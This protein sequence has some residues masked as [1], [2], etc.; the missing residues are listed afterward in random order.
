MI[1][2]TWRQ[3]RVPA[4]AAV[5]GLVAIAILL[6]VTGHTTGTTE[7]GRSICPAGDGR[8][9][10]LS[11]V[12]LLQF[13]STFLVALPALTGAFWGAPLIAREL[14]TGTYRMAWTQSVTRTRWLLVKV[15]LVGLA[16]AAASGLLS[17]M[18]TLWSSHA[19][20][21]GR[22]S[23]PMF[24]ER[25][26]APIGDA[27]FAF[28]L[29]LTAGLVIRRTLPA[30][31]TTLVGFLAV[32]LVVTR[33]VRPHFA[34]PLTLISGRA[35]PP[36][37]AGYLQAKPGDWVTANTTINPAGKVAN[38]NFRCSV[39]SLVH[40]GPGSPSG[41]GIAAVNAANRACRAEGRAYL[42]TL[43]Q[44]LVYQPLG[45]YWTFQIYDVAVF[46][47]AALILIGFCFWWVRHRV[48]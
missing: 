35:G 19:V 5:A 21:L 34:T 45:R 14:E 38:G 6:A 22:F 40:R 31:A 29:G 25:G 3:F 27:I 12:H 8:F 15:A 41:P 43:R 37:G 42:A 48:T 30:M 28:A 16:S 1:W 32:R 36:N 46:V 2:L 10:G 24:D 4:A 9:L 23:P 17:L 33:W 44:V 47:G 20:N 39:T 11:H 13:L 18:L 26:I 7:C